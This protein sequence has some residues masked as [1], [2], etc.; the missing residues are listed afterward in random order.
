MRAA[1]SPGWAGT[2]PVGRACAVRA[3][4]GRAGGRAVCE[5]QEGE[6]EH[7]QCVPTEHERVRARSGARERAREHGGC[8]L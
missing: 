4:R 2:R 5:G 1:C 3:H 6:M 8:R 7:A